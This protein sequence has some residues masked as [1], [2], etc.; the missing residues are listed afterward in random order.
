MR[1]ESYQCPRAR[2]AL[3]CRGL[4]TW[5][6]RGSR[7]GVDDASQPAHPPKNQSQTPAAAQTNK[8]SSRARVEA[9]L[10][11]PASGAATLAVKL[12][13]PLG[14]ID[15][16]YRQ[17]EVRFRKEKFRKGGD[18][19][20]RFV[21]VLREGGKRGAFVSTVAVPSDKVLRLQY[22]VRLE[23]HRADPVVGLDEVP[24]PTTGGWFLNGRAFLPSVHVVLPDGKEKEVDMEAALSLKVPAGHDLVSSVATGSGPWTAPS[25]GELRNALYYSGKFNRAAAGSGDVRVDLVSSDFGEVQLGILGAMTGFTL[26]AG[27]RLLGP[28]P[29]ER[30]LIIY[31]RDAER[32]GGVVG[33]GISLLH[34]QSPSPEMSSPM[35]IV[36]VHELMHLWNRGDAWWLNEGLTR[37]LELV[38]SLRLDRATPEE[39]TR[40]LLELNEK[41]RASAP[42]Q[43]VEKATELE[44]Y[45]AGALYCFCL[46]VELRRAGR[47]LFEVH[48]RARKAAGSGRVL[49]VAGFFDAMKALA[50][51]V[52]E[53]AKKQMSAPGPID[54]APC[55]RRAGFR[56]QRK[57]ARLLSAKALAVDVMKIRGHD[58]RTSKVLRTF[59]DSELESGD[60]IT[61]V[62]GKLVSS[63][64]D[65][66]HVVS[67]LGPGSAVNLTLLRANK[68]VA[69]A[70]KMPRLPVA[71]FVRYEALSVTATPKQHP[72]LD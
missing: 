65:I 21:D 33:K 72:L 42:K 4:P 2:V 17:L 38:F 8:D 68:K 63:F 50:P 59:D 39:A 10:D 45:S 56:I 69:L 13:M 64:T 52:A 70:L 9:L 24:H 27:T 71:A 53:G 26:K 46:D 58:L 34:D 51:E 31:D 67:K 22:R 61:H 19:Y 28:L 66:N 62:N 18:G 30:L 29:K 60:R 1:L 41:Y 14:F 44:A 11:A 49:S 3:H 23:H 6:A 43:S 40:R 7:A 15:F 37:Y 12:T 48:R 16:E 36:I 32:A 47:S 57:P 5:H 20:A 54:L 35:G 25:L 55:L